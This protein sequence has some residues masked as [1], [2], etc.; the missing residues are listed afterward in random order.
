MGCVIKCMV[1][2]REAFWERKGMYVGKVK[3]LGAPC[4]ANFEALL[5]IRE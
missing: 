3:D 4:Y 2:Y 5:S 1:Y